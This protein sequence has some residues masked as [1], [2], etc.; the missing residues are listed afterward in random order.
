DLSRIHHPNFIFL[1]ETKK[2][3]KFV[4]T[5]CHKLGFKE[6]CFIVDPLGLSGG[7][8]LLWGRD[9]SI[10]QVLGNQ[11]SIE[12]EVEGT[13]GGPSFWVV[14]TYM[15]TDSR[16][17]EEQWGYLVNDKQ[18][19]GD[20][21][22]IGGDWNAICSVEEKRG[23][24][25]KNELE[26]R[27]FNNF[28]AQME[29][30]EV[31]MTGHQFTWGNNRSGGD[32]IE[33]KIDQIFGSFN[34]LAAHPNA[35]VESFCRSA[36]NHRLLLLSTQFDYGIQKPKRRFYFDKRWLKMSGIRETV[37]KAWS[38]KKSGTPMY[39]VS[40]K[41]K[42]TRL[43]IL[44]WSSLFKKNR[45]REKDEISNRLERLSK[46]GD[47]RNWEEWYGLKRQMDDLI[48]KEEEYWQQNSRVSW[49]R[50]GDSNSKYFPASVMQRRQGNAITRLLDERGETC[51][52]DEKIEQCVSN[53]YE[54]LFTS[55][56]SSGADEVLQ[57][58]PK[59]ISDDTNADL[60]SPVTDEEVREALFS[61]D[62]GKAPGQDG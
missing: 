60:T 53:F 37:E 48:K 23:G 20:S 18:K 29:M 47:N 1:S 15:S 38:L 4:N 7:L 42:E 11:F 30:Q 14:F 36:S 44:R 59:S 21:W 33:E 10:L 2:N 46:Q 55:E 57:V 32:F 13:A 6:R 43:A 31:L 22:L 28:I 56:G 8:L 35:R 41:I 39:Q 3:G 58:I 34:W 25:K 49:L 52:S 5:V 50:H 54:N 16:I 9:V 26:L 61:M 62:P 19:W 24:R 40:E 45:D 51:E 17:R 27:G 12:V